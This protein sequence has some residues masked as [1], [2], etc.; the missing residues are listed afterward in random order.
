MK[1]TMT[2]ELDHKWWSKNKPKLMKKTGLAD[3]LKAYQVAEDQ[4]D[5]G[6]TLKSLSDVKRKVAEAV[7]IAGSKHADTVTVLK[8]YPKIIDKKEK[9]LK[10]KQKDA[11]D[12]AKSAPAEAPK[13]KVG[14]SVVIWKKDLGAEITKKFKPDWLKDLKGYAFELKLNEDLL[15][16][17]EKEGD[18]VTPQQMVDDANAVTD[19]LVA[20]I[21][22]ELM[23]TD[24]AIKK[25]TDAKKREGQ[26]KNF[27]VKLKTIMGG[28]KKHFEAIPAKRWQAF[29]KRKQQYKDYKVKTGFDITVGVLGVAGG[30]VGVAGAAAT[31]G[32]S[33]ALGIVSLVRGVAQLA[34]KIKDAAQEAETVEKNLKGDLDTLLKRY[35]T[36]EGEA[37][38]NVQGGAEVGSSVLKGILGTDAPFLATLP[39]CDKNYGL[40]QNKVAGLEVGGR[41]LSQA[42]MKGL[43]ECDKLE[44]AMKKADAKKAGKYLDKLKKARASLQ[45]GLDGCSEM[46]KRVSNADKNA[47]NLKKMLDALNSSNPKYAQIFDKVFPVVVNLTLAGAN[48]GVGFK[49]ASNTLDTVNTALGLFNDIASE[50]K[51]QLEEAIG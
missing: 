25:E 3:A 5:W 33:L 37:K 27:E 41:K 43:Q 44:K 6:K 26:V 22:K 1:A 29:V 40:W 2:P 31:G 48:A 46:M 21:A 34:D 32:A 35:R 8:K 14:K 50:G 10:A 7:K 20:L 28:A 19:K 13:Q 42:I 18:Y 47:P 12:R 4:M 49:E 36:A 16:V 15:D 51:D 30:A 17:L 39:K 23:S 45:K 9:D 24:A 38:K 11:E